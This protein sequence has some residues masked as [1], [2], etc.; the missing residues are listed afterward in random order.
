MKFFCSWGGIQTHQPWTRPRDEQIRR[1]Y[2]SLDTELQLYLVGNC[3]EKH[4]P[5]FD[6]DV[7]IYKHLP[8]L[9]VLSETFTECIRK[10]FEHEL[11]IDIAFIS[12][13]Y[14]IPFKPFYKIRPDYQFYKEFNGGV[15]N[16]IYKADKVEQL[17]PQLWRYDWYEPHSNYFKGLNRGYNFKGV[18]LEHF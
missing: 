16:P 7:M 2:D 18:K 8:P 9:D 3:V 12:E 14:S 1:W 5:T 15:Y 6:V 10:G 13:W 11:L 17:A 4:S